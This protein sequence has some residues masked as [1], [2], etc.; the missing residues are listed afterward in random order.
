MEF[1]IF[2]D[3]LFIEAK[4]A[5]FEDFQIQYSDRESLNINIYEGDVEKYSL[6]QSFILHFKGMINGKLGY[7]YTEILDD[8]AITLLIKSAKDAALSVE[9]EDVQ[10]IYEG[11]KEYSEVKTY[12]D[13]LENID[14]SKLIDL[15]LGMESECKKYNENVKNFSTCAI[16][17][18]N[19]KSGIMNS[20]GLD[21]SSK[22]NY[23]TSYVVPIVNIDGEKKDGMG[24][25]IAWDVNDVNPCE[26]AKQ[27]VEEALVKFG[28]KSIPSG[29]YKVIINN[30]AMSSLLSTFSSIFDAESVQKGLSLLKDK[31]GEIIASKKVSIVDDPLIDFGLASTS[32][33]S[34]GVATYK[35]DVIKEGKLMTLLH[36]LKTANKAGVKSTGNGFGGGG[37]PTNFFIEKGDKSLEELCKEIGTGLVVTSFAGLHSGASA[38]TGDFSLATKGFYVENGVK[39]FP[40]EQ[41]TVSGNF[42]D[43]L[44]DII[45]VANDLKFPMSNIG[46]PSVLVKELAIAGK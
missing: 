13:K 10:F 41:I 5:G 36:N 31:E 1:K 35:K 39:T 38:V 14:P 44:K 43:L 17:Y 34:E 11:D 9:N 7:S 15:A 2:K 8:D 25:T 45:E 23:L 26:I 40:V 12:S 18:S 28:A 6:N 4:K 29:K 24:Y 3:K 27:G 19:S 22:D 37:T 20:K 21:L 30:E 42:Y 16:G 33:D 46:S 32:F